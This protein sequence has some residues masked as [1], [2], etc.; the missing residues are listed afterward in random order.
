MYALGVA[1]T[2]AATTAFITDLSHRTRYGTAHGLFGSIYDVGDAAGPIVA[3][4]LV[5]TVGYVRM[6][7]LIAILGFVSAATFYSLT[8][9][10][11][12]ADSRAA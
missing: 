12:P 6:F 4:L 8:R 2:S 1:V 7:Q 5:A 3:G 10:I 11:A 9:D